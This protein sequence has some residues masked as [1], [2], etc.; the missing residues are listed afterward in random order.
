MEKSTRFSITR[1]F[2]LLA[3]ALL[4]LSGCEAAILDEIIPKELT[5]EK[6]YQLAVEFADAGWN[7]DPYMYFDSIRDYKDAA[8]RAD[9]HLREYTLWALE[10]GYYDEVHLAVRKMDTKDKENRKLISDC[11]EHI[12]VHGSEDDMYYVERLLDII[13]DTDRIKELKEQQK[14]AEHDAKVMEGVSLYRAGK[15]EEAFDVLYYEL[16]LY[17]PCDCYTVDKYCLLDIYKEL[18][19]F[20]LYTPYYEMSRNSLY[21][22]SD[23]MTHLFLIE[24]IYRECTEN[25]E[26]A[27]C[28]ED[29]A[30]ILS[31]PAFYLLRFFGSDW[32]CGDYFI[33]TSYDPAS[34]PNAVIEH[35]LPKDYYPDV[36]YYYL[37]SEKNCIYF[38]NNNDGDVFC[39]LGFSS[40]DSNPEEMYILDS[41]GNRLT[42]TPCGRTAVSDSDTAQ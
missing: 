5:D 36:K 40:D 29:V 8:Q 20:H 4:M 9:H 41:E 18:S 19:Y 24:D 26:L 15:Y 27:D 22:L 21:S 42:F 37:N 35:N 14:Q 23:D 10:K 34:E 32:E 11:A 16:Y 25:P 7:Y 2:C 3:A 6:I 1:L 39:L 28:R 30:G 31:H 13:G 12:S 38:C 17:N 33:N